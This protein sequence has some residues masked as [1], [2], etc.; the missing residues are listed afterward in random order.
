M[1]IASRTPEGFPSECPLCGA[2]F[3]IE[4]SHPGEDAPCPACGH[5]VWFSSQVMELL[6]RRFSEAIGVSPSSINADASLYEI[7]ASDSLETVEIVMELEEEFDVNL[8][9]EV[10]QDIRTIGDLIRY[11]ERTKHGKSNT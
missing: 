3:Q 2:S 11:L 4:F 10:A 6:Q 9:D 1:T 7:L 5:L 8:P